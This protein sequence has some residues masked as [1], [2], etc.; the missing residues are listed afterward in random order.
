MKILSQVVSLYSSQ[1]SNLA[2]AECKS[3][4]LLIE[5]C[6]SGTVCVIQTLTFKL[7]STSFYLRIPLLW[8]TQTT[9][10]QRSR[11]EPMGPHGAKSD[12]VFSGA[13][14]GLRPDLPQVGSTS[15][16]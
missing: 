5:S 8:Q 10:F 16:E 14:H 11:Q 1:E 9:D 4:V 7:Y 6:S 13:E 15:Q 12:T 2:L 3:E